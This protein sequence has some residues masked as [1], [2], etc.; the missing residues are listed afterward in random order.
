M[1]IVSQSLSVFMRFEIGIPGL[2]LAD[3]LAGQLDARE[4]SSTLVLTSTDSNEHAKQSTDEDDCSE[5]DV[6]SDHHDGIMIGT[7]TTA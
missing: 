3:G 4:E 7:R 6:H 5:N 1:A 2:G